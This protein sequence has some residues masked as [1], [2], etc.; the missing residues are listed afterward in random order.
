MNLFE[1]S[2]ELREKARN[3]F[4]RPDR[5]IMNVK[6]YEALEAAYKAREFNIK[7]TWIDQWRYEQFEDVFRHPLQ[8][9]GPALWVVGR[10]AK[11]GYC[12]QKPK[13]L[14]SIIEIR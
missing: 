1:K 4:T 7:E 6:E 3:T 2:E 5:M 9:I 14:E 8:A 13:K 11:M 12:Q 10:W